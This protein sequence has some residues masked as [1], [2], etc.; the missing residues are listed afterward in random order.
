MAGPEYESLQAFS[1]IPESVAE[2]LFSSEL[3]EIESLDESPGAA[4]KLEKATITVDNQLS[5]AHTLLQIE[6]VDQKGLFYDILR[7]SKECNIWV[8]CSNLLFVDLY[9]QGRFLSACQ[10][11][12]S[13]N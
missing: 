1:S 13:D 12:V 6:C 7:T 10:Y 8:I 5:P 2:E 3:F 4:E 9:I 11:L